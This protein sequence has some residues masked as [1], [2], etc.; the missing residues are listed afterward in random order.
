MSGDALADFRDAVA[1]VAAC[2]VTRDDLMTVRT[3][4][5]G[6]RDD[7]RAEMTRT[8]PEIMAHIDRLQDAMALQ[9]EE[10]TIDIGS[11]ERAERLAKA[12]QSDAA[13]IGAI[14]TPLVRLVH[15][16]RTQLDDLAEQVRVLKQR[17]P[18]A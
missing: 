8:R 3:E 7:L 1:D 10:R 13:A 18:A 11:A 2:I 14:V 15:A 17:P 4:M 6:I 5:T 16:M 9:H 12:A